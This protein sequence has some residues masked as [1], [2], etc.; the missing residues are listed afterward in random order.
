MNMTTK[1][2]L[3]LPMNYPIYGWVAEQIELL[4]SWFHKLWCVVD[5]YNFDT[6]VHR[7]IEKTKYWML[8]SWSLLR[9]LLFLIFKWNQYDLIVS[10]MF[11]RYSFLLWLLKFFRILRSCTIVCS[12]SGWSNNEI[13]QVLWKL[14]ITILQHVYFFF[15]RQNNYLNCVNHFIKESLIKLYGVCIYKKLTHINYASKFDHIRWAPKQTI[16]TFWYIWRLIKDKW[17]EDVI[18]A[19]K[20]ANIPNTKLQIAWSWSHDY[21]LYLKSLIEGDSRITRKGFIYNEEKGRFR[22][23]I[24]CFVFPTQHAEWFPVVILEAVSNNIPLIITKVGDWMN[25]PKWTIFL[26]DDFS[27]EDI[28]KCMK[29]LHT[30]WHDWYDKDYLS[31]YSIIKVCK[32]YLNLI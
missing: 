31:N 20:K 12:D 32:E 30:A 15:I 22:E 18:H 26:E 28:I 24:D 25:Y 2:V 10:R 13:E 4:A 21:E 8:Y 29:Y 16:H 6:Q 1:K 5:F 23:E 17:V 3:I 27:L 11:Y 14:K 19:F 7:R 9:F